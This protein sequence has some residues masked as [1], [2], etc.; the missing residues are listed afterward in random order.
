MI[1]T[2]YVDEKT[3]KSFY[4]EMSLR[5]PVNIIQWSFWQIVSLRNVVV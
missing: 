1:I 4:C 3:K 2:R 5:F